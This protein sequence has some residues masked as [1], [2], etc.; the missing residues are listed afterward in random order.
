ME[1]KFKYLLAMM[2]SHMRDSD[3]KLEV[4]QYHLCEISKIDMRTLT[5][6]K[7]KLKQSG[8]ITYDNYYDIYGDP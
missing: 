5:V 2:Y 4:T 1:S 6:N 3:C 8:F 7:S